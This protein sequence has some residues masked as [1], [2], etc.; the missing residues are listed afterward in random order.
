MAKLCVNVD[1]V[2]TVRQARRIDM[3]D[4]LEAALIA[5]KAGSAGITVHLREDRRHIQDRDVRAIKKAIKTKLNLEMAIVPEI[6]DFA[7]KI[8]P[9][10]VTFVPERRQEITTEGGLDVTVRQ[11]KMRK[12]IES[13]RKKGITVSLFIDPDPRQIH[14]SADLGADAIELNTGQYSQIKTGGKLKTEL[15][16]IEKAAMLSDSLSLVTHAGHGLNLNNIRPIA[17][18]SVI[19]ELNIGHSII[20]R[21]IMVGLAAAVTEMRKAIILKPSRK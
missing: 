19:E 8:R 14:A 10:Q 5:E 18:I 13:F 9:D 7:L 11:R 6:V 1:H 2:A 15:K 17:S 20:A 21:A 3:P 4:P 12:I 16:K